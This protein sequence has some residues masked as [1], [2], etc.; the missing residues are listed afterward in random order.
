MKKEYSNKM[1]LKI[2]N[3]YI[4]TISIFSLLPMIIISFYSHPSVD[5]F[6]YSITTLRE[7]NTNHSLIGLLIEC[8]NK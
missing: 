2:L 8:Y 5:D 4:G 3:Y 6:D 7:W 1:I